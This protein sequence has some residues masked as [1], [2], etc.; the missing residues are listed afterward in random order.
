VV[1]L[2]IQDTAVQI[3]PLGNGDV[4]SAKP[5]GGVWTDD[6]G[7]LWADGV[8]PVS[9]T[10]YPLASGKRI[11]HVD[12]DAAVNG[13]GSELTPLNNFTDLIGHFDGVNY[14]IGTL[15]FVGGDQIWITGTATAAKHSLGVTDMRID[16]RRDTQLGTSAEPTVI[17]SWKGMSRAKFDGEFLAAL[18]IYCDA[19]TNSDNGLV[20]L[21]MEGTRNINDSNHDTSAPFALDDYISF[22]RVVS[23]WSHHNEALASPPDP[24]SP[25]QA[26]TGIQTRCAN[27][28]RDIA[29][30]NCKVHDNNTSDGTSIRTSNN[31]GEISL[32]SQASADPLSV[33]EFYLNEISD[34][35]Y[36]V[37]H[38]Q[39]GDSIFRS[40]NNIIH[41]CNVGHY[42]RNA[43]VNDIHHNIVYD[44]ALA[45]LEL[46]AENQA[47]KRTINYYNN[48]VS[49]CARLITTGNATEVLQNE[50]SVDNNIYWNVSR[51]EEVL[52][53]GQFA[54]KAY[55]TTDTSSENNIFVTGDESVFWR[56]NDTQQSTLSNYRSTISDSTSITSDPMFVDGDNN[57]YNLQAGSPAIDLNG[58]RVG[59]L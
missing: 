18:G 5:N 31:I 54:S 53:L 4:D 8:E 1:I 37:R 6:V 28:L 32:L 43:G 23:C 26:Y 49:R 9:S 36:A 10:I 45:D 44:C 25:S 7:L 59:A 51:T 27:G 38:K 46:E 52:T 30:H 39:S 47:Q 13:D 34:G 50:L 11:W 19:Q 14:H 29:V 35:N 33:V 57:D 21:N 2:I 3:I 17:R 24:S 41:D 42:T 55:D 20:L 15:G 56:L 16:M 40:Y 58:S 12:L 22:G 48:T